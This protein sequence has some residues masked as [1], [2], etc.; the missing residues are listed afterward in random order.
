VEDR[1]GDSVN[2]HS[3]AAHKNQLKVRLGKFSKEEFDNHLQE[4]TSD[5]RQDFEKVDGKEKGDESGGRKKS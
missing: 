2:K 5:P 4:H 3:I 1:H